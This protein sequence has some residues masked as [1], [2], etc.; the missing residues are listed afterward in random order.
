MVS[1]EVQQKIHE[2]TQKL[3]ALKSTYPQL[4]LTSDDFVSQGNALWYD[5][6]YDEAFVSYD[7]ALQI[8]PNLA[9]AWSGRG[10]A[11]D[12][13][14]RYEEALDSYEHAIQIKPNDFRTWFGRGYTLE[15]LKRYE[16]AIA[17]YD[18]VIQLKPDYH[19]AWNHRAYALMKCDRYP[20]AWNSLEKACQL[21]PHSSG[22]HYNR[23][24]YYAL[25]G[26]VEPAIENLKFES[27]LKQRAKTN[28]DFDLIRS[29][30]G[31]K[32]FINQ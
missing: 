11:L 13:L 17:S 3:E 1:P 5:G 29:D 21:K 26:Q 12:K 16:E 30:E 15:H 8:N 9:V 32:Q 6:R 7:R 14:R 19:H 25:K 4:Y 23:A 28:P 20:E 31:F 22:L 24:C 27:K 2:L 18:Q 10:K